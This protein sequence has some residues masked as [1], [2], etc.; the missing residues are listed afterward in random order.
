[1]I[2][3]HTLH[4][5]ALGGLEQ[6]INKALTLDPAT[7]QRL[8]QLDGH[9]FLLDCTAPELQ[10]YLIPGLDG[11]RLCGFFEGT[12]DTTLAGSAKEFAKLASSEDPASA[13]INGKVELHGNSQA[14]IELQKILKQLDLDWE[15][16]LTRLF[17]DVVGHQLGQ[18]LRKG[19]SFGKQ[20]LSNLKRQFDDYIVEESELVPPRWQVDKFFNEVDQL[21]TRSERLEAKLQRLRQRLQTSQTKPTPAN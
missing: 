9:V 1:M 15:A 7:Q 12:A 21:A 5:A 19:F 10:F 4:T 18:G 14:L 2:I 6:A 3:S 20:A 16:P 11:L 13:L 17:G 8:Q